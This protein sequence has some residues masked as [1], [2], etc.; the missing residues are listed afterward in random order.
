MTKFKKLC[1]ISAVL[2]LLVNTAS[3]CT[4][5]ASVKAGTE[6]IEASL[7]ALSADAAVGSNASS[8]GTSSASEK[9]QTGILEVTIESASILSSQGVRGTPAVSVSGNAVSVDLGTWIMPGAYAE[10][11]VTL[12][13][14]G[15]LTAYLTRAVY[16][17]PESDALRI[18]FPDISPD[19]EEK[20]EVGQTCSFTVVISLDDSYEEPSFDIS[21]SFMME[22]YYEN[23][24][25]PFV[26]EAQTSV[27]TSAKT[28]NSS[29]QNGGVVSTGSHA[30]LLWT[31]CAAVVCVSLLILLCAVLR[32]R[33]GSL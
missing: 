28:D 22:L 25:K 23:D 15:T 21:D 14:T 24:E 19:S 29:V 9:T 31:A 12:R 10:I 33:K 11:G 7:T 26:P 3:V 13:N 8:S 2:L 16:T 17:L 18:S 4:N 1:A 32:K 30:A 27:G 5:A 20:L 6:K